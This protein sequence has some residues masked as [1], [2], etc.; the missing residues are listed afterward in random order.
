MRGYD[1][2]QRIQGVCVFLYMLYSDVMVLQA[3]FFIQEN[4]DYVIQKLK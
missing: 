2:L 1:C 3:Y 4:H